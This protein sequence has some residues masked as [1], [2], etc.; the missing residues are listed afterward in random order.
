[1]NNNLVSYLREAIKKGKSKDDVQQEVNA[2]FDK[3]SDQ[4]KNQDKNLLNVNI[5]VKDLTASQILL[6][7]GGLITILGG[8][9]YITIN[10]QGWD[11]FTRILAILVPMLIAYSIG[12]SLWIKKNYQIQSSAFIVTGALLFPLFLTITFKELNIL[13]N[14]PPYALGFGISI[15]TII[16]YLAQSF[17]FTFSIWSLISTVTGLVAYYFGINL[18]FPD[19][20][21]QHNFTAWAFML[22]GSAY[23][24]L[25]AYY[26]KYNLVIRGHYPFLV[27]TAT[28]IF[29]IIYLLFGS[30]SDSKEAWLI[31]LPAIG[32][33]LSA[34]Y[35]EQLKQVE[36]S[37]IVYFISL[38]T[39]LLI[40]ARLALSGDLTSS[41]ISKDSSSHTGI[42]SSILIAGII[43][44]LI[45][46]GL[47]KIAQF[48]FSIP[49]MYA[50]IFEACGTLGILG[51]IFH[52]GTGGKKFFTE[53]LLLLTSLGF[54]F[55]SIP[56]K[57]RSFLYFGTL[58]LIVYIFDIG[59]E[60]FQ[61]QVG[62]PITLFIA[63]LMSMGVGFA[64]EKFRRQYFK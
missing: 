33:F 2:S 11:P 15:F 55:G 3:I 7:I 46:F 23:L 1:M 44:L 43:Y 17:Y 10:W 38:F 28:C 5:H 62:W 18:Y 40:L 12:T 54:I 53:S 22:I 61:N 26:T 36:N 16:F 27:G 8:I 63:G 57:S 51:G 21:N 41:F 32:F 45:K 42:G 59:G 20:V 31:F 47:S 14:A 48:G 56:V 58:F 30:F 39:F 50:P 25:G 19:L 37:K 64:M 4:F 6:A 34:M 24:F 29:S 35:L 13:Q 49:Q 52:L 60:Y 9:I